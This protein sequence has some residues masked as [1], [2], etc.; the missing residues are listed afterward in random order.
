MTG[1]SG[2]GGKSGFAWSEGDNFAEL[3]RVGDAWE[4]SYGF[5]ATAKHGRQVVA[6]Q[7]TPD[8]EDAVRQIWQVVGYY[9]AA[10]EH[11]ERIR[12]DLLSQAGLDSGGSRYL[13]VPDAAYLTGAGGGAGGQDE[14]VAENA[15]RARILSGEPEP[16]PEPPA[17]EARRPWW[18]RFG[19]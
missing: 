14:A 15:R 8:Y 10:P 1:T 19:R 6:R 4:I 12:R 17:P 16:A 3:R 13:P 2:V 18:K 7:S 11:A 5:E 9:F